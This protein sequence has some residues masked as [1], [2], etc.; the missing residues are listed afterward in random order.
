[1][2]AWSPR[3]RPGLQTRRTS[4]MLTSAGIKT[5]AIELGFDLC[6]IAPADDFPELRF[7]PDWLARGYGGRMTYLNR[8][9]RR[10]ADVRAWL[11]SAQSVVVV[12]CAYNT[13]E[14]TSLERDDR[15]E[16]VIARYAWG[17]DYHRSMGERLAALLAWMRE[18]APAPF[19][20]VTCVDAGPLQERVYAQ[21]AGLGWIGKNTCLIN[22]RLGSWILL[23]AIVTSLNLD[24]ADLSFDQ[25]GTCRLCL[26]ACPTQAFVE[27]HVLDATKCLSYLTI[28][29]RGSIPEKQRPALG[30]RVFGCDI[31]Q[32]V[33]PFN[34]QAP[35]S[36]R[37]EW[38][39]RPALRRPGLAALW[40]SSDAALAH[41]IAGT[42]LERVGVAGLRRNVAVALG[43]ASAA[44][45][46]EALLM[47]LDPLECPSTSDPNVA[48][49][50]AWARDRQ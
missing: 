10:R 1:M 34:Q 15:A 31:C 8:T 32:D 38:Q 25:C 42:A 5:K 37:A 26:E 12:A 24:A 20:A 7:L 36:A 45:A 39:P 29:I 19:D 2:E 16:A 47:P 3:W 9:A 21:Y 41:A 11:P 50:V 28:E 13:S 18:A 48:E 14:P 33:C 27:P 4:T 49:H 23:G 35:V 17:D 22:P 30:P 40:R 6:G 43:N 46:R 44:V